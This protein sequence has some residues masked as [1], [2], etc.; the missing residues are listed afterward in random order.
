VRG[1]TPYVFGFN[2]SVLDSGSWLYLLLFKSFPTPFMGLR[3]RGYPLPMPT[4]R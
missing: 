4:V 3:Q 2:S 1:K